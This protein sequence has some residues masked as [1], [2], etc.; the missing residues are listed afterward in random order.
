MTSKPKKLDFNDA[1]LIAGG[2]RV[3]PTAVPERIILRS[4]MVILADGSEFQVKMTVWPDDDGV[5][6]RQWQKK[7]KPGP[8]VYQAAHWRKASVVE[9]EQVEAW[10]IAH[11]EYLPNQ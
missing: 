1:R 3:H 5:Y 8:N 6:H 9:A 10:L 7:C 11:P 4:W 2:G